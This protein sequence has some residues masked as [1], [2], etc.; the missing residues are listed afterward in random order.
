MTAAV[1]AAYAR[2]P[3]ME[4]LH[5]V[6]LFSA[7]GLPQ[8]FIDRGD[9][10]VDRIAATMNG[11]LTRLRLPNQHT[12]AYQ[13][14][15]G[16]VKWIG[17]GTEETL[18]ALGRDGVRSVLVVPLSFVSDHIET[19][20]EVDQLFAGTAREAGITGYYRSAALNVSPAFIDALAALVRR[21]LSAGRA[22]A[23][24][25]AGAAVPA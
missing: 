14:R 18:E 2:I 5:T 7:H 21:H 15:T 13:S 3:L 10:Y 11:I 23:A 12:L 8:R 22:G 4:R 25:G 19:L 6:V 1:W 24:A 17:P 20:Y 16:P 9:P